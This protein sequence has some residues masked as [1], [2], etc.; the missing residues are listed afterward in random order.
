MRS[1]FGPHTNTP[2]NDPPIVMGNIS[3]SLSTCGFSFVKS[4]IVFGDQLK[5]AN[6]SKTRS[7]H[8]GKGQASAF[9]KC[10]A[11]AVEV[12]YEPVAFDKKGNFTVA[13]P[14]TF[15]ALANTMAPGTAPTLP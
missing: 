8:T 7:E 1:R 4:A 10:A 15:E 11:V 12:T 9:S 13:S 5:V 14:K 3:A 2:S 6:H